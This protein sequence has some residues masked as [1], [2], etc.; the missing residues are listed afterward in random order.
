LLSAAWLQVLYYNLPGYAAF[1]EWYWVGQLVLIVL[2]IS[3]V[4]GML[5]KLIRPLIKIHR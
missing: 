2:T 4:L 1:K 5:Y 3:L